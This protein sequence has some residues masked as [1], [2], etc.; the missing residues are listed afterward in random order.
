HLLKNVFQRTTLTA[1]GMHCYLA[2][3]EQACPACIECRRILDSDVQHSFAAV[4]VE[5]EQNTRFEEVAGQFFGSITLN[6]Q[7]LRPILQVAPDLFLT[8]RGQDAA[9]VEDEDVFAK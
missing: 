7:F 3:Q 5:S 9:P 6:G 1:N 4:Q 8:P 2:F